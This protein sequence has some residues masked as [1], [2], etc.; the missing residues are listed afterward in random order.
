M[1]SPDAG[2][3]ARAPRG[4]APRPALEVEWLGRVPYAEA[5]ALQYARVEARR[6]GECGD[7]LLL[8]EHPPVVT[9]GR[10][11]RP[12][13]LRLSR[14]ELAARGVEVHEVARGGDVTWHGPGQLIG[15]LV[16]DLE[17]RGECDVHAHLR[18]IEAILIDALA[19]VGVAAGRREGMTGVFVAEPSGP[20]SESARPRKIASIGVGL[21]GWTT[22]H[23]FALNVCNGPE[24][25]ASIV[26]CGLHGVEMTSL[27]A[28]LGA[29]RPEPETDG[30]GAGDAAALWARTRDR[31]AESARRRL[32]PDAAIG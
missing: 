21:R 27:A 9:L 20:G 10:S 28:E 8:L 24:G 29:R 31:V 12:E 14:A 32:A 7:A 16:L 17:A 23:G 19:A 18:R 4:P 13:N 30:A 6:R 15:Y 25:F 22:L 2:P 1:A 11:A 26:P 3:A 5:L